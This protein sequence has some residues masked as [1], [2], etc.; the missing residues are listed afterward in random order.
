MAAPV[1]YLNKISSDLNSLLIVCIFTT[2]NI[3]KAPHFLCFFDNEY[4]QQRMP[5]LTLVEIDVEVTI[6]NK[7][8]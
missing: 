5:V 8:N 7:I 1:A 2:E 6:L 4:N 3:Q